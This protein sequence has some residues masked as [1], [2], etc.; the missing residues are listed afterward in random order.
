MQVNPLLSPGSGNMFEPAAGRSHHSVSRV[1]LNTSPTKEPNFLRDVGDIKVQKDSCL[2]LC[3]EL[4]EILSVNQFMLTESSHVCSS[5][6]FTSRCT[7]G[8]MLH[9]TKVENTLIGGPSYGLLEK[10]DIIVRIDGQDVTESNVYAKLKGCDL[11]GTEVLITVERSG[12]MS[13]LSVKSLSD[14]DHLD[15]KIVVVP[16]LRMAT[17]EIADRRRMFD[18]FT[19]LE[20]RCR[21]CPT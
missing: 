21:T 16:V 4:R 2:F 1:L 3:G 17:S 19:T 20:V 18:L 14:F 5:E 8:I 12:T 13:P 15:A 9:G 6:T 11:P 7:V 10:G